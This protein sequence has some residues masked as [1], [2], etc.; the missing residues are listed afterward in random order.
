MAQE[1][2][3][4]LRQES[5]ALCGATMQRTKSNVQVTE[6]DLIEFLSMLA[7]YAGSLPELQL[8]AVQ[9]WAIVG[10]GQDAPRAYEWLTILRILKEEIGK[11][12]DGKFHPRRALD[13]WRQLDDILTYAIIEASQLATDM[14][15]ADLLEQLVKLREQQAEFEL[16]KSSFIAVAAHEL[17]TPLTILEGYANMLRASTEEG[18]QQRIFVDGLGNGFRRMH[19]VIGDMIDVSLIDL[20]SISLQHRKVDL[21]KI[22]LL[23][24]DNVDKYFHERRVELVIMPFFVNAKTYGD[25]EKLVK[26]MSK[27]IMNGLKYTPDFGQVNISAAFIRQDEATNALAGFMDIQISDTGIGIDAENLELIFSKFTSTSDPGLHSSS[28]TKFKGGGPGLGLAIARGIIEAHGGRIWA[29]S[30]GCDEEKF[31]GSTF[32]IE[33]PIW[34]QKPESI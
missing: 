22:T 34:L 7:M 8:S 12:L 15:R 28:K 19:E 3:L 2:K 4:W 1:L 11:S 26:A 30:P 9:G 31:P 33:L 13:Y 23:V 32:H 29:E 17:K 5:A 20:H 21:E 10:I 18:S 14:V 25:E 27:I 16:S 24:A 6:D